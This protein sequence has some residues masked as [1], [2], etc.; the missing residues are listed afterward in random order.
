MMDSIRQQIIDNESIGKNT[1]NNVSTKRNIVSYNSDDMSVMAEDSAADSSQSDSDDNDEH[2]EIEISQSKQ[3]ME[4]E[5][6]SKNRLMH[7]PHTRR[8]IGRTGCLC[9]VCGQLCLDEATLKT[10][11]LQHKGKIVN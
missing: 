11:M 4:N 9:N 5:S 6:K 1:D 3:G 7:K 2:A 10:H 8:H